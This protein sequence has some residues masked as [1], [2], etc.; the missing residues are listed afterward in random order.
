MQLVS[1]A[2]AK[3]PRLTAFSKPLLS[4][5]SRSTLP[6]KNTEFQVIP[7]IG[8]HSLLGVFVVAALNS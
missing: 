8:G 3:P 7:H 5:Q 4:F 1:D 6:S 2:A